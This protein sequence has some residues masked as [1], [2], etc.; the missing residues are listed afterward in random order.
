MIDNY[1]KKHNGEKNC[2]NCLEC[3]CVYANKEMWCRKGKWGNDSNG[4]SKKLKIQLWGNKF[5]RWNDSKLLNTAK[6][7]LYFNDVSLR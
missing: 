7:C 4:G 5:W 1:W 3:R 6:T 2:Q